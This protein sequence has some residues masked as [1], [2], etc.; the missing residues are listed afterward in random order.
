MR[1]I[2]IIE[3]VVGLG[4]GVGPALGSVVYSSLKYEHTMYMFGGINTAGMLICCCLLPNELNKTVKEEDVA[5]FEAEMEDL[6]RY[7]IDDEVKTGSKTRITAWTVWCNKHCFFALMTVLFGSYNTTFFT[8]FLGTTLTGLGFPES[9]VGYVYGVQSL[10]YLIGAVTLPFT[11]EHLSRK[12]MF[13]MATFFFGLDMFLLGPSSLLNIPNQWYYIVA[14]FPI[15]GLFQ[16]FVF[17]P[18]IPEMLE[19]LVVDLEIFEG[20]DADVDNA[21]ND[22]VN[23]AYGLMFAFACF[24]SPIIGDTLN[25]KYT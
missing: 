16:T 11:C 17:I 10:F 24:I 15:L 6:L 14:G 13:I 7:D 22:K 5:A 4:L 1:Y 18:I 23:D 21:L 9:G 20:A 3:I 25:T 8:G 2:T 19:R 12:V